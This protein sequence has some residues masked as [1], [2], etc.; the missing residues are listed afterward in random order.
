MSKIFLSVPILDRPMWQSIS[1]ITQ[2]ILSSK[3]QVQLCCTVGDSLISRARS[4]DLS[5]FVESECDFFMSI[6]SDIEV[7]PQDN[8]F[9]KLVN[10]NLQFVGGLYSTKSKTKCS[11]VALNN[12]KFAYN[13]GLIRMKWMATGCWCLRRD[14]VEQ[15]IKAYPDLTCS[16]GDLGT[17]NLYYLYQPAI[18]TL[19]FEDGSTKRHLLSE[20]Y[21]FCQRFTDIGGTI[22]ADTSVKLKHYGIYPYI[23][24]GWE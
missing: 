13:I 10:H 1:S 8:I 18:V 14:T 9:D 23:L 3:H 5:R 16:K 12:T 21:S 11:S 24:E 22:Y 15:M 2:S 20:D 19:Q 6:D 4:F 7:E 17:G